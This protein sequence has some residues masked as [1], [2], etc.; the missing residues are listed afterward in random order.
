MHP[1]ITG[2]EKKRKDYCH[3]PER[4]REREREKHLKYLS[5]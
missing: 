3:F 4:E 1:I 5:Q 2:P